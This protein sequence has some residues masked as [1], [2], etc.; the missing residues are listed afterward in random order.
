MNRQLSLFISSK[1]A[2]LVT[3]RQ[4]AQTAL[5]HYRMYGWLW[6]KDAG[7]RP[8]S[9]RQTY[10]K[11]VESCD[12]YIGLFWLGYGP[13]TIEEFEHARLH[14]KP[15]LIYEKHVQIDQRD[16][17]LQTFL[18]RIGQVDNPEGLTIC[19]FKTA[20]ELAECVQQDVTGL[21][22]RSFQEKQKQPA[23]PQSPKKASRNVT[24]SRFD[25]S[26]VVGGNNSG[27]IK[28]TN[29]SNNNTDDEEE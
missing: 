13:Y 15:C 21:L 16:P 18:N 17:Q 25:H 8:E 27:S 28:Q 12:L 4:V 9:I 1:M 20:E 22:T 23:S 3:E 5:A 10:L 14:H 7:A 6:E 29:Y 19:R 2:E 11:E 26:I 24:A